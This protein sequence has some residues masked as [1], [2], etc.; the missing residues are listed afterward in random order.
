MITDCFSANTPQFS[1][2]IT[3]QVRNLKIIPPQQYWSR[4]E[5]GQVWV[6]EMRMKYAMQLQRNEQAESML[7]DL[8]LEYQARQAQGKPLSAEEMANLTARRNHLSQGIRTNRE[9]ISQFKKQQEQ[10]RA[11]QQQVLSE[12]G[13]HR[14]D[15][16][17]GLGDGAG[18]NVSQ[19]QEGHGPPSNSQSL[20]VDSQALVTEGARP[21]A[22]QAGRPSINP[23]ASAPSGQLPT[24]QTQIPQPNLPSANVST[25]QGATS[26]INTS[27][28]VPP[29]SQ[30]D[31]SPQNTSSTSQ[32]PHPLSHKAAMAQAARSYSQSNIPQSTSQSSGPH[33]NLGNSNQP[34]SK[35]NLFIPKT[36]NVTPLQPVPMG[37]ARPTLSGGPSTGALGP[38]GQ[39]GIQKH[40]G[41]VLEGEGE[42][43]LSKKKLEELVRQVTGGGDGE[44]GETLDPD[45][46]EVS[47]ARQR[48]SQSLFLVDLCANE[49]VR[50]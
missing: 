11:Q 44:G 8:T 25:T 50:I 10:L 46:E 14:P 24:S 23:S 12:G 31:H 4:P 1:E 33:P 35:P 6:R 30:S 16:T 27:A 5:D 40:P 49:S 17:G 42:R 38:M 41:Y 29:N 39:P 3:G 13:A 2:Q 48:D 21:P 28:V 34:N 47:E 26:S 15:V 32:G 37:S 20:P 45:V 7:R 18:E 9:S 19:N 43:V 36:L 22:S